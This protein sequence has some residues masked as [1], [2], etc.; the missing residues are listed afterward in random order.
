MSCGE[1]IKKRKKD[2]IEVPVNDFKLIKEKGKFVLLT[3]NTS[4]SYFLYK[5][6]P[7][8]YEYEL[9][10]KFCDYHNLDLE[11]KVISDLNT[12][13]ESL[14]NGEGDLIA[15][16]LTITKNRMDYIQFTNPVMDIK[17]VLVQKK[18]ENWRKL[19]KDELLDSLITDPIDLHGKRVSVHKYSSFYQRLLNLQEE[20]GIHI[21]IDTVSGLIDSERLIEMVHSGEVELTVADD[22]LAN[23]NANYYPDLYV[24]TA[25][26]FP[27]R[28]G[29]AVSKKSDSLLFELNKWL[30]LETV[31]N[32]N[33]ELQNK[34][35]NYL[36]TH[37]KRAETNS[38][39][40]AGSE[41]SIYDKFIKEQCKNFSWDWKLLSAL[42]K[43]ESNFD[44]NVTSWAG[45]F[46]LMQLMPE[47]AL[48]FGGDTVDYE[49]GNIRTGI[50]FINSLQ[51]YWSKT[52]EDKDE[53]VKFVLASYNAG[54]G[55][56]L[57]AQILAE[58]DGGNPLVWNENVELGMRKKAEKEFYS[59]EECSHGFCRGEDVIEY[60]DKILG[61]YDEF[62]NI[63]K[64]E[65]Q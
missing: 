33:A 62:N 38:S 11:V 35:F 15:C 30:E 17:Q 57:D 28:V 34:Y 23:L 12:M 3:E 7:I 1:I 5:D 51:K 2:K 10:S 55:H 65:S 59:L 21:E 24:E 42:I 44:P 27:Q 53:R 63:N 43:Q 49:F 18:P 54:L 47:T 58:M 29:W 13:F 61:Y 9:L 39:L 20:F 19:K 8:G 25:I 4:T 56:V 46:G 41:I 6:K 64:N 16:N 32:F 26:S 52:I 14:D 36:R 31:R 37:R 50:K 45:A 48:G 60:V 22:N 40:L